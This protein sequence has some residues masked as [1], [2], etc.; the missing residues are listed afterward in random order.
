MPHLKENEINHSDTHN[1]PI[2]SFD[3]VIE[4]NDNDI[5]AYLKGYVIKNDK[6]KDGFVVITYKGLGMG[7]GKAKDGVIK[8]HYPKGLR[9]M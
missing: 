5:E 6:V 2:S 9:N 8:N 1:K 3:N 4:L 7:W